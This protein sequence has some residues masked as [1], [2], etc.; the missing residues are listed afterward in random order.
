MATVVARGRR[1]NGSRGETKPRSAPTEPPASAAPAY[2]GDPNFMASLARGLAV[3]RAFSQ[4]PQSQTI[5]QLSHKTGIPR[6]AVRRCL[7]TL[8]KLGY[9]TA[10]D[11]HFAL[12]PKV[13]TLG[14][15]YL[16]STP[17]VLSAQ[18]F[19]DQVNELVHES[20]SMA[21]LDDE[22]ILYVARSKKTTRIMSV[23]LRIGS[24][25]PA[26]CSSMGRVLLAHLAP[27]ELEAYLARVKL[28][29]YTERTVTSREKLAQ[30][31]DD[32]RVNGYS[33]VDQELELGLRSIAVPVKDV[34]GNVVSAMNVGA[35]AARVSVREMETRI[36]PHLRAAACDLGSLLV[37]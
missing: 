32:V 31:L 26:Y 28:R 18:P 30:I 17:L 15:A 27:T 16:S 4:S 9:V 22:D 10:N 12:Q 36:L 24:R 3:I 2:P 25:L 29:P 6:A 11:R 20:C 13:L 21:I 35:Q 33:I 34:H 23:D 8:A 1:K 7:Y 19:L 5:A 14:H 37:A